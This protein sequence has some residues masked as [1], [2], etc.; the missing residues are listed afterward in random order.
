M[1]KIV[2]CR[3][4]MQRTSVSFWVLCLEII[5]VERLTKVLEIGILPAFRQGK[6]VEFIK[7]DCSVKC[8]RTMSMSLEQ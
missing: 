3:R 8:C 2:K 1:N 5:V 7:L 4:I 6:M